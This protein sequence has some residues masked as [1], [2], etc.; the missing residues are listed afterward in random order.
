[1][2]IDSNNFTVVL[3]HGGR[4][5]NL[6]GQFSGDWVFFDRNTQRLYVENEGVQVLVGDVMYNDRWL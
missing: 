5:T 6:R 2:R 1:M 4:T 3:L